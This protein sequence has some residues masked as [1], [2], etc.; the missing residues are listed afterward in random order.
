M[1]TVIGFLRVLG[2]FWVVVYYGLGL[3]VFSVVIEG[4]WVWILFK[5]IGFVI[6]G[7]I[8][9]FGNVWFEKLEKCDLSWVG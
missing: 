6:F 1:F 4:E 5:E 8:E 9:I 3:V 2:G 7:F